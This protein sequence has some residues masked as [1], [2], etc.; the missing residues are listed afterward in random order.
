MTVRAGEQLGEAT[1]ALF[2]WLAAATLVLAAVVSFVAL[3]G[4]AWQWHIARTVRRRRAAV[5]WLYVGRR[6]SPADEVFVVGRQG[7]EPLSDVVEVALERRCWGRQ[8]SCDRLAEALLR[9]ARRSR[10]VRPRQARWLAERLA[11]MDEDGFVLEASELVT[12]GRRFG[13]RLPHTANSTA[14]VVPG[15]SPRGRPAARR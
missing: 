15:A 3:V 9:H 4:W 12:G 5:P 1:Q 7:V 8:A 13:T 6:G 11:A 2:A 14:E 10:R